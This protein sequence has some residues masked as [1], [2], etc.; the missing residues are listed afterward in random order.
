MRKV[1]IL[2]LSLSLL[3]SLIFLFKEEQPDAQPI[4]KKIDLIQNYGKLP[5]HFIENRGQ[6]DKR[7]KFYERG[8]AHSTYFT[9]EGVYVVLHGRNREPEVLSIKP[10]G[11]NPEPHITAEG[12]LSGRV[13]Y[14]KGSDPEKW[15]RDIPTYAKVRYKE[16]YEGIDVVFYGNQRRLEYDV[17]VKPGADLKAVRFSYEGVKELKVNDKGELVAVLPSGSVIV[18]DK[19]FIYQEVDGKK[20]EIRG[21]FVVS[22]EDKKYYYGFEVDGYREGYAL[23]VD[24]ALSYSSFLG[25]SSQNSGYGIAV[26]SSGNAYV[27]GT[28]LS[29]DFPVQGA[30]QGSRGGSYDAFVT[31]VSPQG[32][33][34]VFSTY[35]GG[36]D[37]DDGT[38]VAV[39]PGGN[40]YVVGKTRSPDFPTTTNAYDTSCGTDGS[41]DS[42][43]NDVFLA[44]INPQGDSLLYS[45]FLGGSGQD[46]PDGAE[47]F[48]HDV[49]VDQNGIVYIGGQ[50]NS[51]D[52]PVK[53][54]YLACGNT[55]DAFVAKIDTTKSG[56]ASL[57]YSSCFDG[58][59]GYGIAVDSN[60]NAYL[61]GRKYNNVTFGT[62]AFVAKVDTNQSGLSS[63]I[64]FRFYG[65]SAR[66]EGA[67]IAL[68]SSGNIYITG[69]TRS[70]DFPTQNAYDTSCGTDGNCNNGNEDAFLVKLDSSGNI[71]YATYFGGSD[72]EIGHGI[73][74]DSQGRAFIVGET[75]SPDMPTKDAYD[76]S[77]GN[78][79][80]CDV[81]SDRYDV[82]VAKFDPD[83]A[84]NAS[85]LY[86][87]FLGG[88]EFDY[89]Y[90][91]ALDSSGNLYLT[92]ETTSD[93]F[94]LSNPFQ[95]L[96]NGSPDVFVAKLSEF[97]TLT[98]TMSGNGTGSVTSSPGG[99]DCG[100]DCS[101]TYAANSNITLSVTPSADSSFGGWG[102]A[103][104]GCGTNT[105]CVVTMSTDKTCVAAFNI[106]GSGGD[107]GG[108]CSASGIT[109]PSNILG[110][111]LPFLLILVRRFIRV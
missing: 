91:A 26:D 73:A 98:V 56:N 3:L 43:E 103:C 95:S 86:S 57:L 14:L 42:G 96:R 7:V 105:T 66:D 11:G 76:T 10:L 44:K 28:T 82:F 20:V 53:N 71:L 102:D 104:S 111:I 87:T 63:L 6:L 62:D 40:V 81:N 27:V 21:R 75:R 50:A 79:G 8:T 25:G 2:T 59:Y 61:T 94:P 85:L 70:D 106:P 52:F 5:L 89:G 18:Q 84:G 39:D 34:I 37:R 64:F 49:A 47:E 35:L 30:L 74:V 46:G 12:K 22:K 100:S 60:G 78:D 83:Q 36:S 93:D 109:S 69:F 31:K 13:N 92:G 16:V 41:C 80:N 1:Y 72:D 67:D 99:I 9:E 38:G 15:K 17:V 97:A 23:V 108:G 90:D 29:S 54:E 48:G 55:W 65:G 77:C 32:N 51:T 45:T 33:S 110:W 107:S 68:D 24:P 4:I 88:S 19:P 101:E 58:G